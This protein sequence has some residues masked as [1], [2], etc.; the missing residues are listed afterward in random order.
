MLQGLNY[1]VMGQVQFSNC[2]WVSLTIFN[3]NLSNNNLN[4]NQNQEF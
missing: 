3:L 2:L 1:Q 4:P